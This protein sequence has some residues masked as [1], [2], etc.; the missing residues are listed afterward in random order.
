MKIV[1]LSQGGGKVR[2]EVTFDYETGK[3]EAHVVHTGIAQDAKTEE[4]KTL[5]HNLLSGEVEGFGSMYTQVDSG[6]TED[7][8]KIKM[9]GI[10]SKPQE[11]AGVLDKPKGMVVQ[12]PQA[13]EKTPLAYGQDV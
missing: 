3:V 1:R 2:V 13:E 12:A 6:L 9:Q 4:N 5:C 8:Y 10:T 7:G 11:A